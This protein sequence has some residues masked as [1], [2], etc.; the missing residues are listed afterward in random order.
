M[1]NEKVSSR[2]DEFGRIYSI[3][4]LVD[5]YTKIDSDIGSLSATLLYVLIIL[6]LLNC[7]QQIYT[8]YM[9]NEKVSLK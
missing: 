4:N 7:P 5:F 3:L 8:L 6:E 9:C 2:S 1:C